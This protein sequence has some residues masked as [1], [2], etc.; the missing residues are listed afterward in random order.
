MRVGT[1]NLVDSLAAFHREFS[2]EGKKPKTD[3][4][5]GKGLSVCREGQKTENTVQLSEHYT[6][7]HSNFNIWCFWLFSV[8]LGALVVAAESIASSYKSIFLC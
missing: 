6:L 2:S 4:M 8:L 1:Q 5:T 7:Y 3:V